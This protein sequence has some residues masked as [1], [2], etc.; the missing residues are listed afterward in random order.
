MN[1]QDKIGHL[2]LF[3]TGMILL[4]QCSP[5]A[6]K[7]LLTFFF[8]GVPE[9]DTLTAISDQVKPLSDSTLTEGETIAMKETNH[10]LHFPYAERECA[11][12]HDEQSPGS[13][14]EPQPGLCYNCHEDLSATYPYLHGPV[15]GGYCTT[16]HDPHSSGNEKLL[17]V[18]GDELCFYCHTKEGAVWNEM[19][20]DFDGMGCSGCHNSHGGEDKNILL[21]FESLTH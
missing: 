2:F 9:T 5:R 20:K 8:D 14:T 17:R 1:R 7:S 10:G 12:C 18:K 16:C 6:G 21:S 11:V 13:M 3:F 4:C 19:H 15:A